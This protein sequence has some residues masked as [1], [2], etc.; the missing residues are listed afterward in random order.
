MNA[1]REEDLRFSMDASHVRHD[2]G[3]NKLALLEVMSQWSKA[4]GNILD[5]RIT[6]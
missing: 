3:V 5:I 2:A 1:R 4:M 6:A